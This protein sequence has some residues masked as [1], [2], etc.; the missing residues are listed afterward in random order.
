MYTDLA[1]W[2]PLLSPAED[3]AAEATVFGG[4]LR[5]GARQV[6]SV[7]ELGSG[8]GHLASHL[9]E[10]AA[11]TLVDL[12]AQMLEVSRARNPGCVHVQGDMR[13]VRL[14][15]R[16]D[17]VL[18]HDAIDYLLSADD[19]HALGETIRAHLEPGGVAVL[20]P[21]HVAESFEPGT[22][23]GGAD[24]PDGRGARY[25]EWTWDPDS[26]DTWAQADYAML[27]RG[28]DGEVTTVHDSHRFGLFG[29]QDWLDMLADAA[30]TAVP[31][32]EETDE[33]RRP[34]TLFVA[35]AAD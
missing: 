6:E 13:D 35:R 24:A 7:L 29:R 3:Y 21:D 23:C 22:E 12:S 33:D 27:L 2:W 16:F 4:L 25:L 19:V 1:P 10:D 8:G 9:T 34:R 5:S 26:S 31:V 17:A 30:L 14:G 18:V 20:A 11:F 28:S 32:L 15:R